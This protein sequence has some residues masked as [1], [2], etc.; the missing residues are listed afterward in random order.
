[1]TAGS[2]GHQRAS[3]GLPGCRQASSWVVICTVYR[4]V[5]VSPREPES[6]SLFQSPWNHFPLLWGKATCT[7]YLLFEQFGSWYFVPAKEPFLSC[8]DQGMFSL[9]APQ[10]LEGFVCLL[11]FCFVFCFVLFSFAFCIYFS[12][13]PSHSSS[14]VLAGHLLPLRP[15]WE[16]VGTAI[17]GDVPV[18]TVLCPPL[19]MCQ[20]FL[21][22][23]YL[24]RQCS[25]YHGC[26]V[27]I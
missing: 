21:C 3:R 14:P 13:D 9:P 11:F 8:H 12:D 17:T 25:L 18:P 24:L 4:N 10:K 23:P 19:N 26:L 16:W 20:G 6:C 2:L 27:N 7:S 22:A 1:M 15:F 5:D